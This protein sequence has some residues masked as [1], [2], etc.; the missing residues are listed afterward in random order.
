MISS[1]YFGRFEFI[2]KG[3]SEK[4]QIYIGL[5]NLMDRNTGEVYVYDWR[6][7]ISSIFYRYE[8]GEA[9]V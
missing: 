1:P 7:P 8:L 6:A 2:E 3:F 4:E 5:Y 9:N